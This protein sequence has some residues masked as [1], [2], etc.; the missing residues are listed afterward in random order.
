LIAVLVL[1]YGMTLWLGLYLIKRDLRSPRLR[2]A[3][4]G[5]VS[6]TLGIAGEALRTSASPLL[7]LDL[8]RVSWLLF[9]FPPLLYSGAIICFLPEESILRPRL[10]T[11][12]CYGVLPVALLCY[13]VLMSTGPLFSTPHHTLGLGLE[14]VLLGIIVMLP[15]LAGLGFAWHMRSALRPSQARWALFVS[16]L[17]FLLGTELLLV[18]PDGKLPPWLLFALGVDQVMFGLAIAELDAFDQGEAMLPD[19]QRSFD[20]SLGAV[21][22]FGGPVILTLVLATGPSFPMMALLLTTVAIAVASQVF[23]AQLASFADRVALAAFPHLRQTRAELRAAVD[24]LPRTNIALDL[25]VLD[26]AEF[27]RLTRRALSHYGDLARLAVSPLTEL[28]VVAAQLAARGA[29]D[30]ALGRAIELKGLLTASIIRL[31]P[32]HQGDFGTAPEWRYYNAL[33]FP[34]VVGLKPYSRRAHAT[35]TD[36]NIKAALE[37]FRSQVPERTLHNWQKAAALLVAQD[38]RRLTTG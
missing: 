7:A 36:P 12:W 8:V 20:F 3:G 17:L 29:R 19:L 27:A 2:L 1:L 21:T 30:D 33:Y 13:L 14:G 37:W 9:W 22:I 18:S 10:I 35:Q 25:A 11:V 4:L 38:I 34:Y 26:E 32:P 5:M 15:P 31:K 24:A 23:S 6:Y 28:P 16:L